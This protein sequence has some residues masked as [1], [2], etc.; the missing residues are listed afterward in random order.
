M[1]KPTTTFALHKATA[2]FQ[3]GWGA[4][5]F[6]VSVLRALIFTARRSR[7]PQEPN[8][9]RYTEDELVEAIVKYNPGLSKAEARA[10]YEA[11]VAFQQGWGAEGF[12]I[13]ALRAGGFPAL[14]VQASYT[15]D[16]LAQTV[17]RLNA[18]GLTDR[19]GQ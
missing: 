3:Q 17:S 2:A 11:T 13:Y 5:G 16:E 6:P 1:K 9:R 8:P 12:S 4:E 19:R 14:C 7:T 15:E 18:Y 10:L